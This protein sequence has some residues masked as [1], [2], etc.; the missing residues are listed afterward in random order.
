MPPSSEESRLVVSRTVAVP[1]AEFAVEYVRSGGP[2]GQNV[3]KVASK[4]QF[5]WPVVASPS[6]PDDVKQR[7]LARYKSRLTT[8]GE[9]LLTGQKY[10]DQ[11]RNLAD[12]LERL[13]QMI[14]D[15]LRPP[16][17][18]KATKP[19]KASKRRRVEAKRQRSTTKRLRG[20]PSES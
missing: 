5:R 9:L 8:E 3:N 13:R 7:F 4:A 15:V 19:T 11:K 6:L 17:P 1:L 2:G 12:C 14:A 10:R 20:A 16:T 18:R